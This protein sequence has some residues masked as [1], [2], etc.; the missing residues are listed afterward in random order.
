MNIFSIHIFKPYSSFNK[1]LST[2]FNTVL[3]LTG[4]L[5]VIWKQQKSKYQC[6]NDGNN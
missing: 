4:P 2:N 1:K 3:K 5:F 6:M